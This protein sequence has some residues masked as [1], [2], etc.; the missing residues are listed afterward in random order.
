MPV[1]HLYHAC[2]MH[3]HIAPVSRLYHACIVP[4][5]LLY[6]ASITLVLRLYRTCIAPV[7]CLYCACTAPVSCLYHACAALWACAAQTWYSG[8]TGVMGLQLPLSPPWT[9][10]YNQTAPHICC[11]FQSYFGILV[12]YWDTKG[13][14]C[15]RGK[16]YRRMIISKSF[17][18]D[19]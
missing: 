15:T 7:S 3:V 19:S 16:G 4:V 12:W 8:G 18:M 11:T 13:Q 9:L 5:S 10:V 14:P 2:I 17:H 6:R 1:S